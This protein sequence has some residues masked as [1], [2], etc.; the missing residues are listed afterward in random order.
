MRGVRPRRES[1]VGNRRR[2]WSET[3]DRNLQQLHAS[4]NQVRVIAKKLGRDAKSISNRLQYLK[5]RQR[6]AHLTDRPGV[7][8]R[9]SGIGSLT[10]SSPTVEATSER[11]VSPKNPGFWILS[12]SDVDRY[13]RE[14]ERCRRLAARTIDLVDKNVLQRMADELLRR[15]HAAEM[16]Q[17]SLFFLT[18]SSVDHIGRVNS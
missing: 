6:L 10:L 17:L 3:D 18:T 16:E 1:V 13:R 5:R 9:M 8:E 15:A 7:D 11:K 12:M 2:T 4:G 14:A